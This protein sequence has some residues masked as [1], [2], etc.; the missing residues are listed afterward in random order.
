MKMGPGVK[1]GV[2]SAHVLRNPDLSVRSKA[3][4]C[5]LATYVDNDNR[6]WT[7]SKR[8]L[9]NELGCSVETVKRGL[10][11]LTDLGYLTRVRR[12]NDKRTEV[13]ATTR[14]MDFVAVWPEDDS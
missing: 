4:Y 14:L 5:L 10:A 1:F 12:V 6:E 13:V 2:V 8:R 7:I 11:E 3:L 9:A